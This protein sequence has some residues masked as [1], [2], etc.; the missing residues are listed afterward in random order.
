MTCLKMIMTV[1]IPPQSHPPST[2]DLLYNKNT[3]VLMC[4]LRLCQDSINCITSSQR[5]T[6]DSTVH[7]PPVFPE[8]SPSKPPLVCLSTCCLLL[9]L[10]FRPRLSDKRCGTGL[11]NRITTALGHRRCLSLLNTFILQYILG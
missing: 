10:F 5:F 11:G 4:I 8:P 2:E 6:L 7:L 3:S 9:R 1:F